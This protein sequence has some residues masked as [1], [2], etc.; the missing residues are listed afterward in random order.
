MYYVCVWQLTCLLTVGVFWLLVVCWVVVICFMIYWFVVLLDLGCLDV[1]L[2]C[3][4]GVGF[5]MLFLCVFFI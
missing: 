5:A 2:I 3:V 4:W 1:V